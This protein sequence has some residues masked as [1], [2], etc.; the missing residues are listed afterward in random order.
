MN[1]TIKV[2]EYIIDWHYKNNIMPSFMRV[3]KLAIHSHGVYLATN[4]ISLLDE[5][6]WLSEFGPQLKGSGSYCGKY[7]KYI[8]TSM[9]PVKKVFLF[10]RKLRNAEAY[11]IDLVCEAFKNASTD[12]ICSYMRG[13]DSFWFHNTNNG[14]NITRWAYDEDILNFY[15]KL[16]DNGTKAKSAEKEG[17]VIHCDFRGT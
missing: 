4:N 15:K 14:K 5:R 1:K 17:N 2:A 10:N 12:Q 8:K 6:V 7:I 13:P 16:L 9:P 3:M 11:S